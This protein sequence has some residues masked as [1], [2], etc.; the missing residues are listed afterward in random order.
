MATGSV[1][2]QLLAAGLELVGDCAAMAQHGPHLMLGAALLEDFTEPEAAT[3]GGAMLRVRAAPRQ[4][5]IREGDTG[6]WMLLLLSGTV[7]VT[8]QS[9]RGDRS[10]LAVV[11]AGATLGEMSMLDGEPRNATCTAI[12]AV[13]AGV[14]TRESIAGLIREHPGVGAKLL[15]KLTQ[16]I[17]QRLRN[18]NNQLVKLVQGQASEGS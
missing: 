4:V 8:K 11:K 12:E 1:E 10:R 6:N 16:L 3:L 18:T 2:E 17:A 5:L 7:D 9:P 13:E 14:L 15:V